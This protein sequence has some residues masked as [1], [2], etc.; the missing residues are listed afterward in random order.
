MPNNLLGDLGKDRLSLFVQEWLSVVDA[1][2]LRMAATSN[3][4]QGVGL[5]ADHPHNIIRQ[6]IKKAT[7]SDLKNFL[8]HH[9][10]SKFSSPICQDEYVKNR[11]VEVLKSPDTDF[12]YQ[13]LA[14]TCNYFSE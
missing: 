13:L 11:I 10:S 2:R 1:G 3:L 5:F 12:E 9:M 8:R 4:L 14:I 6:T 7:A